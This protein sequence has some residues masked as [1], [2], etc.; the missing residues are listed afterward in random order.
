M[1]VLDEAA[2]LRTGD[3]DD[4]ALMYTALCHDFGKP[5]TTLEDDGRVRSPGHERLGA[6]MA[7][8]FLERL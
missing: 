2:G 6:T 4:L 1:M 7:R 8:E 3:D 5:R